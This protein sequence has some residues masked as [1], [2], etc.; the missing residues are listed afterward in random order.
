MIF[1]FFKNQI[2]G[3][4]DILRPLFDGYD[5]TEVPSREDEIHDDLASATRGLTQKPSIENEEW[6]K[7]YDINLSIF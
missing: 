1:L 3:H 2:P 7:I 5:F 6:L 4:H